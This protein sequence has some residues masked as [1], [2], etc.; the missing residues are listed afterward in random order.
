[1]RLF[2][3]LNKNS[4]ILLK[5]MV[6]DTRIC[7]VVDEYQIVKKINYDIAQFDGGFNDA[8]GSYVAGSKMAQPTDKSAK[9]P[10]V[11][12]RAG[13]DRFRASTYV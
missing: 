5:V 8:Y 3:S 9:F 1:M 2:R 11:V 4:N 13:I 12:Q 6:K 10:I 7:Y